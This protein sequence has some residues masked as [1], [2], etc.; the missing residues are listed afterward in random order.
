MGQKVFFA[1]IVRLGP[2]VFAAV[3]LFRASTLLPK[4]GLSSR[5]LWFTLQATASDLALVL[6]LLALVGGLTAG[7]RGSSVTKAL[8]GF[9]ILAF[10]V[11]LLSAVVHP[12]IDYVV[13]TRY[14]GVDPAF[15]FPNGPHFPWSEMDRARAMLAGALPNPNSSIV[16]TSAMAELLVFGAAFPFLVA[17][18]SFLNAVTGVLVPRFDAWL[19]LELR[20]WVLAVCTSFAFLAGAGLSVRLARLEAASLGTLLVLPLVVPAA[21]LLALAACLPPVPPDS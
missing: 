16:P 11:W 14:Q 20:G 7:A 4:Y 5:T 12:W 10:V 15:L 8:P 2:V 13:A 1:P 17:C 18:L 6:A 3:M 19:S 21:V 9:L